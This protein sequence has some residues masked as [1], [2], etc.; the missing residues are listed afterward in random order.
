MLHVPGPR[1][2]CCDGVSRRSFLQVGAL[3]AGGLSLAGLLKRRAHGEAAP[4]SKASVIF[5][6]LAGGATQF[7]TYDPKPDAPVEYRGPLAAIPTALPG[8]NFSQF[9]PQQAKIADK[10]AIVRSIHHD[11]SSH[12]TSSHLTL[13]GY[14]LRDPQNRENEMPSV[15]SVAFRMCG[16]HVEGMPGFVSIPRANF[17][18]AAHLGK[19]FNPFATDGDPNQANF[20]VRDLSLDGG[21]NL[22][23]LD[24]RRGLLTA[25]DG[26]RRLIDRE[27][28]SQAMDEFTH[29]A[30]DMVTSEHA[31][32]AF[33]LQR[34]DPRLRDTYGR[35]TFGQSCLLARRLVEAG[36]TFVGIQ[37][38]GWDDHGQIARSMEAKG[39]P[40]DRA[41]AALVSDLYDRGLDRDVLVVATGEFGRTPRVNPS[42]GRDHWGNVMSVLLSGGG[43]KVGQIVGASNSKGEM[44]ADKP[45]RPENV[46]AT[47]YRHLGI[48]PATLFNDFSGRPR[49]LLERRETIA[50]LI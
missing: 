13:T 30:F 4:R 48:D 14:Y 46:L 33:D 41:V 45:Y 37:I 38:G 11:S 20:R 3:G 18:N 2:A 1:F 23:R 27:G 8:V 42:A 49:Y 15:G 35:H 5:L 31:R 12:S 50:E 32:R 43:L 25:F 36:V 39:P 40:Y 7:E 21:I 34:E 26:T 6:K 44:P 22:G 9:M 17:F 29:Q 16:A 28:V 19:A 10:L 47:I 24:D